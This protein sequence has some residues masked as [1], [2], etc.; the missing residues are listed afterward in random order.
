MQDITQPFVK[1]TT[2]NAAL[3]MRFAQSPDMD[4]LARTSAH[5]HFELAQASFGRAAASD[6]FADLVRGLT[7]N[8]STFARECSQSLMGIA[9]EAQ[10][11]VAQRMLAVAERAAQTAGGTVAAVAKASNRGRAR[12]AK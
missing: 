6:A 3:I 10:G 2:A 9:T 8:Y 5:K 7:E 12:R 11:R 4:Q 1:L